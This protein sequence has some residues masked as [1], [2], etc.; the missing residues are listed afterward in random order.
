VT[1]KLSSGLEVKKKKDKND[2]EYW[3]YENPPKEL[4]PTMDHVG[5]MIVVAREPG[6]RNKYVGYR[7][8][9]VE[10]DIVSVLGPEGFRTFNIDSIILSNKKHTSEEKLINEHEKKRTKAT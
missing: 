4:I 3:I 2:F 6:S 10:N 7:I 1:K 8:T 9:K 5:K